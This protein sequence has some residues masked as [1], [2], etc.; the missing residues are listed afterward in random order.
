MADV[1]PE[2]TEE[3]LEATNGEELPDREAMMVM[4]PPHTYPI[5][6]LPPVDTIEPPPTEEA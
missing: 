2:L 6:P 3:E 4:L 1:N 5:D